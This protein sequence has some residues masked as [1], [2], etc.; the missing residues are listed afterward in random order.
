MV[1]RFRRTVSKTQVSLE[2]LAVELTGERNGSQNPPFGPVLPGCY[3]D[4]FDGSGD[5]FRIAFAL[6]QE[7][8]R[9][10]RTTARRNSNHEGIRM[11]GKSKVLSAVTALALTAASAAVATAAPPAG[12]TPRKAADEVTLVRSE[13]HT[14]E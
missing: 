6:P 12:T 4:T 8:F 2:V 14:S 9:P 1:P 7:A 13:E 3:I 11:R 5:L 10:A